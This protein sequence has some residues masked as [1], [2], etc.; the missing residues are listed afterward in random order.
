M[1]DSEQSSPTAK[2][3]GPVVG[4]LGRLT[5]GKWMALLAVAC[6]LLLLGVGLI[7]TQ[8]GS[9]GAGASA[10]EFTLT[11]FEGDTIELKAMRGQVVLVNFWASWCK[12][13]E[14]EAAELEQAYR[15]YRERGVVFV[16][17]NYVDTEPEALA[18]MQRF[19][20]TYPS[21]P[22]LGTK[23]AH[24]YRIRGV[25]ESYVIGPDGMISSVKIGPYESLAEITT[26]LDQALAE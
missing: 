21:G 14:E 25:P 17:V 1:A 3:S 15:M 2:S 11:T 4:W 22:D 18:Y 19:G 16:G 23:I 5:A 7:R 10:P 8:E 24:A 6:L 12:P 13:C 9:V 26:A 20:I